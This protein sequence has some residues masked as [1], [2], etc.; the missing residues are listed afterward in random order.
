MEHRAAATHCATLGDVVE[1][2]RMMAII[3]L[4]VEDPL[5]MAA[6]LGSIVIDL[7]SLGLQLDLEA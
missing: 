7:L 5:E 2:A 4:V 1:Q 3:P 6:P